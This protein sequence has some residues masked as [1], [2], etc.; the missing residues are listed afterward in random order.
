MTAALAVFCAAGAIISGYTFVYLAAAAG[1]ISNWRLG[2]WG[3]P[4]RARARRLHMQEPDWPCVYVH[5]CLLWPVYVGK[6]I[7]ATGRMRA[8]AKEIMCL[9]FTHTI[10]IPTA[11]TD[12]DRVERGLI[13]AFRTS[14]VGFNLTEGN[15]T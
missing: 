12:L 9:F 10:A 3:L 1:G 2:V 4:R 5:F 13:R 15:A 7:Q 6:T 8:E 14:R 11:A